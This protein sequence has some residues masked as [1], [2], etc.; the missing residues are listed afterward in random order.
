MAADVGS[1]M[2]KTSAIPVVIG[3]NYTDPPCQ[4]YFVLVDSR[5]EILASVKC[6]HFRS[7]DNVIISMLNDDCPGDKFLDTSIFGA[8]QVAVI[9]SFTKST[10]RLD[11]AGDL[12]VVTDHDNLFQRKTASLKNYAGR[13]ITATT[14]RCPPFSYGTGDG[15]MN[16]SSKENGKQTYLTNHKSE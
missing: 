13:S 14:F 4:E 2:Y 7:H 16:S 8:A 15:V 11:T 1:D 5:H 3:H 10:Y 9:C 12:H 6:L